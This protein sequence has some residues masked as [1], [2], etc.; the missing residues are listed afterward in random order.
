M[1]FL[2]SFLAAIR[3]EDRIFVSLSKEF[4]D[5][6]NN[7]STYNKYATPTQNERELPQQEKKQ[8]I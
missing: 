7:E 5:V 4:L 6:L 3:A 1:F 8:H 2:I